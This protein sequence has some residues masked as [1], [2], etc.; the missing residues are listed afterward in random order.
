LIIRRKRHPAARHRI[1]RERMAVREKADDTPA[2]VSARVASRVLQAVQASV[3]ASQE[4]V[5]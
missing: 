1:L 3:R 5:R 4:K 2:S